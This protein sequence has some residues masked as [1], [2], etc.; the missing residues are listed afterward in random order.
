MSKKQL[1]ALEIQQKKLPQTENKF[2]FFPRYCGKCQIAYWLEKVPFKNGVSP[3]CPIC[4][5]FLFLDGND[6]INWEKPE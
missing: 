3:H 4:G 2:L 5:S 1:Y 6:A